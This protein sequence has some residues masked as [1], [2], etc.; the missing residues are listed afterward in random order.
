MIFQ[1]RAGLRNRATHPLRTARATIASRR[2]AWAPRQY[3]R[4]H[5]GHA[6]NCS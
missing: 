3:T 6:E 2:P 4:S 5:A 1:A